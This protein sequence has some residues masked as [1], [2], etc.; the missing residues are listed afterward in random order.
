[1]NQHIKRLKGAKDLVFDAVEETTN[2]VERMHVLVAKKSVRP[3]TLVEPLA[4]LTQ[5]VKTVHDSTASGIYEMIRIINRGIKKLLDAGTGLV[6]NGL[7]YPDDLRPDDLRPGNLQPDNLQSD[8]LLQGSMDASTNALDNSGE[9]FGR[10]QMIDLSEAILNGLYG[11]YLCKKENALDLGMRFRHQG[12]ILPMDKDSL[13]QTFPDATAKVCIFVHGLMCTEW[14]W[15]I[16]AEKFYG[17]P[18][19]T[20]GSQLKADLSYTPLFVRYNTGRHIS[21]NGRRF[22]DLLSQLI[23]SYPVD[24]EE[25]VLIG[26]SMG[27]LVSR[28]AAYY[29]DAGNVPWI[30]RLRHVFCVGS[31][32]LG[33]PLE[34][35]ANMLGSLLRAFNTAGTQ[36]PAQILNARSAGIKDLRFG[37]TVDDEWS[38]KDP[39]AFLSDNRL[40]LPLVDGVG[41]YFIAATITADP[42]HPMG[43]LI[44][45]IMVR[46]PSA[47]GH[48]ADPDRRI[49]FR[50]GLIF[51]GMDHLHM[52][53]HPDVYKEIRNFIEAPQ[54]SLTP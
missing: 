33:A 35:A 32:H 12:K 7:T 34:K 18:S 54:Q 25:I 24:I 46:V 28:S 3:L 26:H 41:Y 37:Y 52:A 40:N 6:T 31:P 4:T 53:N 2:L 48:T 42:D 15:Q 23:D 30:R 49:P 1:M 44:G 8:N 45:D 16:A 20:F 29:G 51:N 17:D 36:A 27:G 11:D 38:D 47:A 19:V 21:E 43:L 50:S 10:A 5:A 13:K 14:L 39:D 22:S 9:A